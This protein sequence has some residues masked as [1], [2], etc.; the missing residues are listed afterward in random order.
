MGLVGYA[1]AAHLLGIKGTEVDSL[2]NVC[3]GF[4]PGLADLKDFP[5]CELITRRTQLAGQAFQ[6]FAP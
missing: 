3:V 5:C 4:G 1:E 6:E 2:H